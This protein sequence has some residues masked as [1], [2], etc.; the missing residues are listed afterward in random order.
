MME[1]EIKMEKKYDDEEKLGTSAR[2][3]D[4]INK[5]LQSREPGFQPCQSTDWRSIQQFLKD[6]IVLCKL[7]NILLE[8]DKMPKIRFR[9]KAKM[10]FVAMANIESFN[11]AAEEYGVPTEALFQTNDITDGRKGPMINVINC[12]NQ[13]G[14]VANGKGFQPAYL[15]PEPPKVEW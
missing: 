5:T 9:S 12:L 8:A 11:L 7:I 15:A 3:L 4:W 6:G 2:V 13:L 14:F 10:A 1:V